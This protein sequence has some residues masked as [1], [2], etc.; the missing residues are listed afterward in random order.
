MIHRGI[1]SDHVTTISPRWRGKCGQNVWHTG[2]Q[3]IRDIPK[4]QQRREAKE[5]NLQT[6]LVEVALAVDWKFVEEQAAGIVHG[7]TLVESSQV[8]RLVVAS[9]S[10]S[11]RRDRE[12][13]AEK[14][15]SAGRAAASATTALSQGFS[16]TFT[17]EIHIGVRGGLSAGGDGP[18]CSYL[19]D[20]RWKRGGDVVSGIRVALHA[21]EGVDAVAAGCGSSGRQV[22]VRRVVR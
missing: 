19:V 17:Q 6:D 21:G 13:V 12:K 4:E 8:L 11:E 7:L 5:P 14:V 2:T 10:G 20:G 18:R 16:E 9:S 1:S 15:P 3:A 22:R